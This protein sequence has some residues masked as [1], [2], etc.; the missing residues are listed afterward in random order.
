MIGSPGQR[1]PRV[2]QSLVNLCQIFSFGIQ[3]GRMEQS[4]TLPGWG[5]TALA[6]P[7]IQSNV[8][9]VTAR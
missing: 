8:M 2:E 6:L 1:V 4:G 7:G 5:S 3:N 9:V